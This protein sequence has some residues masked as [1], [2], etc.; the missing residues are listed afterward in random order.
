MIEIEGLGY[1]NVVYFKKASAKLNQNP[2]TFVRGSNLDADPATPTGNGSGKSLFFG[3]I[4]TVA[5]ASPPTA[6]RKKAKKEVLAKKS[7]ITWDLK[8]GGDGHQYRVIQ[9]P[10]K[11]QIFKD[12]KDIE[13]RTVPLAEEYIRKHIFPLPEIEYYSHGFVSSLRPFLMQMD[14]DSNRLEHL[15]NIFRLDSYAD[16]RTYFA[17][18]LRTIKDNEVKLS[19]LEQKLVTLRAKVK[20]V[21]KLLSKE[22]LAKAKEEYKDLDKRVQKDVKREYEL[23]NTQQLLETLLTVERELDDLRSKYAS[24][25]HPSKRVTWLKEQKSLVR[26]WEEYSGLLK[27]YE[28]SI[29]TIQEKLDAIKLPKATRKELESKIEALEFKHSSNEGRIE[30]IEETKSEYDRIIKKAKPIATELEEEHGVGKSDK[31]DLEADYSKDIESYRTSLRLQSL[32][33]HDHLEGNSCPTCM[34]EVDLDNIRK[35]VK[36]AKQ[37]L[38]KLEKQQDAQNLYRQLKELRAKAK[39]IKFDPEELKGLQEEQDGLEKRIEEAKEQLKTIKRHTELTASLGDVEKP[40]APKEKAETD[41]SYDELDEQIDLCTDILK[42]VQAKNKLLEKHPDFAEYKSVKTVKQKIAGV[43]EEIEKISGVLTVARKKLAEISHVIEQQ[44]AYKSEHDLYSSELAEVKAEIAKL[45]PALEDK[46]VLEVL[47][48]AY[49][50]KG[51]KTIVAN[52]ICGLLETNMNYY[53]NLIYAEP[54]T[55]SIKASET[56]LAIRVDRGNGVASDVR[57]LSGAE[58]DCFRL[59]F[60]IA[61]LPLIPEERRLNMV[62]LDEPTAHMDGVSRQIFV[63][64]FLPALMEVVPHIYV[65]TPHDEYINGSSEWIVCKQRGVSKLITDPYANMTDVVEELTKSLQK[66]ERLKKVKKSKKEGVKKKSKA[67]KL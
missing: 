26:R 19:V 10:S 38:P 64:R 6:T 17:T 27:A 49:S 8:T 31:V 55:F 24:K 54:F 20:K 16:M 66:T 25:E 45:K 4:P 63:E 40:K 48:K 36:K 56:G 57:N 28:K 14:T 1:E 60:L 32:L 42:H 3:G 9:T 12:G 11:Y 5:Y 21:S 35:V 46:K 2:V 43:K 34:S 13:I 61:L 29:K 41:L 58:S 22:D 62:V 18:K 7:K 51:L 50:T 37:E 53:R 59:L 39:E 52:Q 15:S 30:K 23:I 47:I 44:A 33:N 65:I 67:K